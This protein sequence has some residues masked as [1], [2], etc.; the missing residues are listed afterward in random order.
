M[1]SKTPRLLTIKG[2]NM[3]EDNTHLM[4][5]VEIIALAT[6][7][8]NFSDGA[9]QEAI[10]F[11]QSCN[12]KIVILN[13]IG[14]DSE[15]AT[16][17][18]ATSASMRREIKE[19]ID[20]IKKMATDHGLEC[21]IVIKESYQPDKTIVELAHQHKADVIIMGRHG[22]KGL[23]KLLVGS[24]TSKVIGHGFPHVLVVPKDFSIAG[25]K[26]LLATDGSEF[27]QMAAEEA[28]NMSAKCS[29]LNDI[30][31]LSVATKETD[32]DKA[33]QL[34]EA[35]CEKA[36][37]IDVDMSCTPM[38]LLGRP[39][40]VIAATAREKDI[41]IILIGGHG[42]GITKLLMGHVTEKVI[43]RAHCAVLVVEKVRE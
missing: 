14:I 37:E 21:E 40:E 17:A 5:E 19:Y 6:D 32:L 8:S 35:I 4:G 28:I 29:T 16:S 33:R 39:S 42:K 26:I 30:Y 2:D 27:S 38:A 3:T 10:F 22:R 12:A 9:V 24:M 43:G 18:H 31:I 41:D 34:T 20:N 11:A 1:Q 7:G 36:K 13:V 23:L 25:K 15:T